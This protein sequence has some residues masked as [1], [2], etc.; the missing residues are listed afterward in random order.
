MSFIFYVVLILSS[1]LQYKADAD[2]NRERYKST[3]GGK[4]LKKFFRK[5]PLFV[6]ERRDLYFYYY[7]ISI[8]DS[9]RFLLEV[10]SWC[11]GYHYCTTSFNKAWTQV[12]RRFDPAR[13]VSEIRGGEDLWQCSLL[14]IRLNTFRRSPFVIPQKQFIIIRFLFWTPQ[15]TERGLW[16]PQRGSL[17]PMFLF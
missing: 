4:P 12:L 9:G 13:G 6:S 8:V 3:E 17:G 14:E 10:A 16:T 7:T 15:C 5:L 11:S 1:G 2:W